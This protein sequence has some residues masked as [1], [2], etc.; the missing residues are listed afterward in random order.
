MNE[1]VLLSIVIP[2]KNRYPCLINLVNKLMS[3]ETNLMEIVIQDNSDDNALGLALKKKYEGDSRFKYFYKSGYLSVIDNCQIAI[4]NTIG[5]YVCFLGDDDGII[6]QA[7][8]VTKWMKSNDVDSL[9]CN[10]G[11]YCWADYRILNRG[12]KRSLAGMLIYKKSSGDIIPIDPKRELIELLKNGALVWNKIPRVYHGIVRKATLEMIKTKTGSY[13]PGP[14]PDM[15]NAVALSFFSKKHVF[16][17][18][19][20]IIA[21]AS[22]N[23]MAGRGG[24]KKSHSRIEEESILPPD[25]VKYWSK[26]LPKYWAP[27]TIWPEGALQALKRTDNEDLIPHLNLSRIY[28]ELIVNTPEL[29]KEVMAFIEENN[30]PQISDEIKKEIRSYSVGFKLRRLKYH[31][32][33]SSILFNFYSLLGLTKIDADEIDEALKILEAQAKKFATSSESQFAKIL[34]RSN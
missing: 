6:S 1:S 18:Y 23:S 5:D 22:R 31:I 32:K 25:T 19:P 15:S 17:D 12:K 24:Q 7:I 20:I 3:W 13:F 33:V 8:P 11:S 2:T 14:V 4:E 21:G 10:L 9:N 34:K 26:E 27:Q 29:K 28:A 30:S 16:L